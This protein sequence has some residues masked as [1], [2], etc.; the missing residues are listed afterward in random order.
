MLKK[1]NY[2]AVVESKMINGREWNEIRWISESGDECYIYQ[3]DIA[4]EGDK[5][6]WFQSSKRDRHLLVIYENDSSYSWVPE[7]YSP[8][9]GCTCFLLEWYKNYLIFIYQEKHDIYICSVRDEDVNYVSFHGEEIERKGNLIS[10]DTYMNKP[11]DQVRL[12]QIPELIQLEPISKVEAK[13]RG[14]LPL[15]IDR[16]GDF[17]ALN[18]QSV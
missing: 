7:T 16:P 17:L 10:Y 8:I 14:L 5:V 2:H 6:A 3:D 15:N 18:S 11:A 1:E 4:V 9:F 12:I 13:E